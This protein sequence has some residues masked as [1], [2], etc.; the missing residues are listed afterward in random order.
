MRN[1]RQMVASEEGRGMP[2]RRSKESP[3]IGPLV[4]GAPAYWHPL[5]PDH[6]LWYGHV[7]RFDKAFACRF[8]A[9]TT[10]GAGGYQH[11]HFRLG[12][13]NLIRIGFA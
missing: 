8:E 6:G 1:A 12:L 13:D 7:G 9:A 4:A 2:E 11:R 10:L 3:T 5:G